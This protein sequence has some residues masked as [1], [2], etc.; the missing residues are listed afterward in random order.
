M[1]AIRPTRRLAAQ[2]GGCCT[3]RLL[4]A[5][6][7]IMRA[8][9]VVL[10]VAAPMARAQ[11]TLSIDYADNDPTNVDS[12][13]CALGA[14]CFDRGVC[15]RDGCWDEVCVT[16]RCNAGQAYC[17][18]DNGGRFR[19]YLQ[20]LD[21]NCESDG[22]NCPDYDCEAYGEWVDG[23]G[24]SS[25]ACGQWSN[26]VIC[27][28]TLWSPPPPSSPPS[29]KAPA[30]DEC[31][32]YGCSAAA[33]AAV[34][35]VQTTVSSSNEWANFTTTTDL[36]GSTT[37]QEAIDLI[38]AGADAV[39]GT[40]ASECVDFMDSFD[41]RESSTHLVRTIDTHRSF[42]DSYLGATWRHICGF[43][44][45]CEAHCGAEVCNGII[46]E[47]R[48]QGPG[49]KRPGATAAETMDALARATFAMASISAVQLSAAVSG[50]ATV[51]APTSST[52]EI[53]GA[54][55]SGASGALP[56]RQPSSTRARYARKSR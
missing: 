17:E 27:S 46:A 54:V 32:K 15:P 6:A 36:G 21:R 37:V 42:A 52:L 28:T 38:C 49:A 24:S 22:L 11:I 2:R 1:I 19:A 51:A 48:G 4:H 55:S 18:V 43:A 29:P 8:A 47:A 12:G 26:E 41:R 7:Y 44:A 39:A 9:I 40:Y 16:G 31:Q 23:S 14:K 10:A 3:R 35:F 30:A 20:V 34:S 56:R 5:V 13:T 33:C 50:D 53:G 25:A 45:R